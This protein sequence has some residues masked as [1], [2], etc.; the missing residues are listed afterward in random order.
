MSYQEMNQVSQNLYLRECPKRKYA[1]LPSYLCDPCPPLIPSR[2]PCYLDCCC[3]C[4]CCCCCCHDICCSPRLNFDY[5]KLESKYPQKKEENVNQEKKVEENNINQSQNP[6][7]EQQNEMIESQNPNEEQQNEMNEPPKEN[8]EENK[9]INEYANY[10]QNQ[11][12]E[13][14]KKLMLVESQVED[15]KSALAKNPDFN[16]EDAFRL[17]ETNDKGYLDINDIKSGLNL[18]GLNPTEKELNLLMKRFDLQKNGFINF[19]DF[20][21]MVVPFE[22][23]QRQIVENR[24]PKSFCPVRSPNIFKEKT[25]A[26]LKNLF[27]LLIKS[28]DDINNDRK[29]LGTLRLK[30]KD[31]FGLLDK[32][33]KGYFDIDE[34]MVY[35]ANNGLLDNNRDADLLFIRLD[36][37]RNG[38]IDYLEIEDELQ[39][40]Y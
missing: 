8:Q 27:E 6:N 15:A 7:E 13:F 19:A 35:F 36:K 30:L 17:F 14:L 4:C 31:I 22:K 38:K 18:I 25:I 37:N 28:E 24:P 39:T 2:Y 29:T 1:P 10:E 34:M 20:F 5:S 12:N 16:C 11:F 3:H 32:D 40:L 26:D 21:D 9:K 23:N 33:G